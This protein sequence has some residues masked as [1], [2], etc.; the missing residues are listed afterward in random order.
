MVEDQNTPTVPLPDIT[1]IPRLIQA[2]TPRPLESAVYPGQHQLPPFHLVLIQHD[3]P[4][5]ALVGDQDSSA[6]V[7][8]HVSRLVQ[9]EFSL[10]ETASTT[11]AA[12][13]KFA[14]LAQ[15]A[16]AVS[17]TR[18]ADHKVTAQLD[19]VLRLRYVTGQ[20]DLAD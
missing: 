18:V 3:Y 4:V 6:S 13:P 2:Q 5:I 16:D 12:S 10:N 1:S 20:R 19:G 14:V 9:V 17:C 8:G 11:S 7:D 15:E